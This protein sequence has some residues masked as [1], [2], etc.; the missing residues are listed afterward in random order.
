MGRGNYMAVTKDDLRDFTRFADERL[1][2]GGAD[3]IVKLAGEWEAQ[4]R[5]MEATVSDIR[6]SHA[7]I[8]SGRVLSVADAFDGA[9]KR[10]GLG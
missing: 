4:R 7:D 1:K 8:E 2:N 6:Q 9:R 10:L 5:E 3:S